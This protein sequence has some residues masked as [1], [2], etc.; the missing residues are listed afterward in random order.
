MANKFQIKRTA[1]SG[2]TPNTTNSGNGAFIDTGELALNLTDRKLFSSNGTSSFEI[3]SNLTSL[4]VATTIT[5]NGGQGTAGQILTSAG[6]GGN[7]Y[8]SG[9]AAATNFDVESLF[10][11]TISS[12]NISSN[13]FEANSITINQGISVGN[14]TVNTSINATAIFSGNG[15][16]NATVNTTVIVVA[17]TQGNSTI[18]PLSISV[19]NSTVNSVLNPTSISVSNSTSNSTINPGLLFVGNSSGNSAIT[20]NSIFVGNSTV[21][22]V[23]V[24]TPTVSTKGIATYNVSS[25]GVVTLQ[26]STDHNIPIV[27]LG[28]GTP[29][30]VPPSGTVVTVTGTGKDYIDD[31]TFNVTELPTANQIKFAI[32]TMTV[33][34]TSAS[35]NTTSGTCTF[36]SAA[37][38][39]LEVG[40]TALVQ[41]CSDARFN[42]TYTVSAK[43]SSTQFTVTRPKLNLTNRNPTFYTEAIGAS[44]TSTPKSYYA[45]IRLTGLTPSFQQQIKDAF[46]QPGNSITIS[47]VQGTYASWQPGGTGPVTSLNGTFRIVSFVDSNTIKIE[48]WNQNIKTAVS[49]VGSSSS[50]VNMSSAATVNL[51]L[52]TSFDITLTGNSRVVRPAVVTTSPASANISYS[53]P[54]KIS[55]ANSKTET[56]ITPGYVFVGGNRTDSC[57]I[58]PRGVKL[59]KQGSFLETQLSGNGLYISEL[60]G[61]DALI[62]ADANNMFAN[63]TFMSLG[64]SSVFT[65]LTPSSVRTGSIEFGDQLANITINSSSLSLLNEISSTTIAPNY[66]S[67]GGNFSVQNSAVVGESLTSNTLAVSSLV[68]VGNDSVNSALSSTVLT[69]GTATVNA[70]NYTGTSNN[71]LFVGSVSAVNVVSNAQLSSNLANYVTSTNLTN[72]L[73]NY[74]TTAGLAANVATLTANNANYFN[75]EI[76]SYYTNA[77]NINSGTLNT[78]RL[79]ATAN[80]TTA[81]NVGANVNLSTTTINVGN[82]TVNA[83][84]TATSF[85]VANSTATTTANTL[86]VYV[87]ANSLVNATAH[88]IGNTTITSTQLTLGGIVSA[89]GSTGT[90]GYAL[91]S[92]G[93]STNAYWGSVVASPGGVNTNIQYNDSGAIGGSAGFTFNKTTNNVTIANTLTVSAISANGSV[94]SNGQLLV[95]NGSA[96]YWANGT[97]VTLYDYYNQYTGNGSNTVYTLS[98]ST[99][100]NSAIVTINGVV[101]QPTTVYS[102]SS[103]TLTFTSAPANN[104]LIEVRYQAI[105]STQGTVAEYKR[106]QYTA[107]NNQTTFTGPDA[108]NNSLSYTPTYEVVYVNGVKLAN[109]DYTATTGNTVVLAVAAANNDIV[110]VQ[111]FGRF[112]VTE[113]D[114]SF[115]HGNAK[116]NTATTSNTSQQVCDQFSATSYRS[117]KYFIQVT[118][119][120][121]SQYYAAEATVVHNGSAA[122]ISTYGEVYSNSSLASF[123]VDVNGGNVRLLITPTAANSTIKTIRTVVNV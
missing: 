49:A 1:V 66:I 44:S 91:V 84:H 94:G 113:G 118:D 31:L 69:I 5:A 73:A 98:Q 40:D 100:T 111:S 41:L 110:E 37:V 17:N 93:A 34:L 33:G 52:G 36:T 26:T 16:T 46:G 45:N 123:D 68:S 42:G 54:T 121:N 9:N 10:A 21:N 65:Y 95:S 82:S 20:A 107:S 53:I 76:G 59:R 2:R 96:L 77:T 61:F 112:Y 63:A 47:G 83:T 101:Q 106:F 50:F 43:P 103:S 74:Q 67:I 56:T 72:N 108:F 15:S 62:M 12:N 79:P 24:L 30:Y 8:W 87:G 48:L 105:S 70:T 14:S 11:N 38:H 28:S 4:Q 97:V 35:V 22:A 116:S 60:E 99:S 109:A 3:G 92:G 89:N 51:T 64:N 102:V 88:A 39:G 122:F 90:A 57:I 85:V 120:T 23:V 19:A 104:D 114:V 58:E 115:T 119:N 18:T 78:A 80:I 71:T 55:V 75:G 32:S 117:A 13:T 6:S 81:V 86:G 7:V 25:V 29:R 27:D